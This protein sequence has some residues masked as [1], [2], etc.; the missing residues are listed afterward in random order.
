MC[1]VQV[2]YKTYYE[3]AIRNSFVVGTTALGYKPF[4]ESKVE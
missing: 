1:F 4:P 3:P 2:I